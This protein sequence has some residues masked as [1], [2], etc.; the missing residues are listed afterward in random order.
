[1]LIMLF[2]KKSLKECV[3]DI[4]TTSVGAGILGLMVWEHLYLAV[5]MEM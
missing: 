4:K 3:E 5:G 2:V 1:M